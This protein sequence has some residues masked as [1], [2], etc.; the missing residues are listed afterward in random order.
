[1]KDVDRRRDG[2]LDEDRENGTNGDDRKG[3][4][5]Q[6]QEA[7]THAEGVS[8]LKVDMSPVPAHDEL[9]TAE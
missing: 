4:P 1:M 3:S 6:D 8:Q 2:D 7:M 9:D 5:P